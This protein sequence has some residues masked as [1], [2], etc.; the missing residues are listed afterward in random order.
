M[1]QNH[2]PEQ[3]SASIKEIIKE[4]FGTLTD[5][6]KHIDITATQ[7]YS[8]LDGKQYVS[9]FSAVRFS[10]DLGV[11][12]A[13]CTEG[14]LPVFNPEHNYDVLLEAATGFYL[15]VQNEDKIREAIESQASTFSADQS[16]AA[17]RILK[18]AHYKR[19]KAE[20]ELGVLLN[21]KWGEENPE[22]DLELP[23]VPQNTMTLH[24]A[25]YD[26]IRECG[27]PLSFT[28]IAKHINSDKLYCRKDGQPVPA[29][30]ISARVK[31]YPDMFSVNKDVS[32]A[33]VN[34]K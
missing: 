2:T 3:V 20:Y 24:E 31:N 8:I 11:N 30:Q 23:E 6:A 4:K 18:N 16:E 33:K 28:E 12:T 17:K 9:L 27:T 14:E 10:V 25:I 19:I 26:V 32:P 22:D 7:L 34:I 1:A 15:A 29:S 5:Y 13:Y 21:N